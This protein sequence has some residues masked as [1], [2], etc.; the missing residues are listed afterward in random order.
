MIRPDGKN[1][2]RYK[3][4][5]GSFDDKLYDRDLEEYCTYLEEK[6]SLDIPPVIPRF[7]VSLVYQNAKETMLRV[8]ITDADNEYEA[9]GKSINY[10]DKEVKD[11]VLLMKTII[12]INGE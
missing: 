7:S 10:F 12:H 8:L 9:L 1:K 5:D 2:D 6:L 4:D 3:L 11:M